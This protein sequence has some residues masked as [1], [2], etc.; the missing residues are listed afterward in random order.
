MISHCYGVEDTRHL[1]YL[2]YLVTGSSG[3]AAKA[4]GEVDGRVVRSLIKSVG[5]GVGVEGVGSLGT[6][7]AAPRNRR[8]G[9]WNRPLRQPAALGERLAYL[10][11]ASVTREASLTAS[12]KAISIRSAPGSRGPRSL[13]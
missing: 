8:V 13:S 3:K 10:P 11:R 5:G 12:L 1:Q 7:P 4:G 2:G 9:R 6:L